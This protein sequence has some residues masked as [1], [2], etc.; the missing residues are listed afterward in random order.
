MVN[1]HAESGH[2]CHS[3]EAVILM[4]HH[5]EGLLLLCCVWQWSFWLHPHWWNYLNRVY[6]WIACKHFGTSQ[7]QGT[8][9]SSTNNCS[10]NLG[11]TFFSNC[12]NPG[13]IF[14][15]HGQ[16]DDLVIV[17]CWESWIWI[18]LLMTPIKV[19]RQ[20]LLH[21]SESQVNSWDFHGWKND[22][23]KQ[24]VTMNMQSVL[25]PQWSRLVP[26]TTPQ[27]SL[28]HSLYFGIHE[29]D[30]ASA[31]SMKLECP[32]KSQGSVSTSTQLSFNHYPGVYRCVW[33]EYKVFMVVW[34]T[35]GNYFSL[36]PWTWNGIVTVF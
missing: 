22:T 3:T 35:W 13:K 32:S 20:S 1:Y 11:N 7:P 12:D 21:C 34:H 8:Q 33:P 6:E 9:S 18:F 31:V 17:E 2:Q 24:A 29:V 10:R 4:R 27:N 19:I 14:N 26:V 23:M 16:M 15:Q 30:L 25:F 28:S 36:W 5:S